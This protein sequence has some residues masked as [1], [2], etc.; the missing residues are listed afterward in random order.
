MCGVSVNKG[1]SFYF[2]YNI[3][4]KERARMIKEA[5]FDCVIANADKN[6]N[7][8]NGPIKKQIKE[9]KKQ[10]L[11]LSSLHMRY[12]DTDLKH[13]FYDDKIGDKLEKTIKKDLKLA[14][15][16]GFTCVVVHLKEEVTEV[17]LNRLK[18]I[19]TL[20]EKLDVP[21]AIE[22]IDYLAV[23][24]EVFEKID[25]KYLRFCY[26]SGH[27]HCFDSYYD[28]FEN[29]G[30]KLICLHL[31]DND[32]SDDQHT[33][34]KLGDIDWKEIAKKLAKCNEVNLDYELL[35]CVKGGYKA[36]EALDECYKQACELENLILK[37]KDL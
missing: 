28:Y 25:N 5:G 8:Q 16:Y 32:G 31:H 1:I 33:L 23:F 29:Y 35:M 27:N 18:R 30:D 34:N 10:G 9:F 3:N 20:C 24:K 14:K 17:G 4:Y 22:N 36:K 7:H 37:Y 19:L 13:F 15:K 12:S 2:G 6:F 21:I 26:D 11:K